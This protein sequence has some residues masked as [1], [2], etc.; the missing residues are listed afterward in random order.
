VTRVIPRG[1]SIEDL[2][3]FL[4]LLSWFA[5]ACGIDALGAKVEDDP[6]AASHADPPAGSQSSGGTYASG[7]PDEGILC[8]ANAQALV[9]CFA[10]E[11]NTTDDSPVRVT[12]LASAN[13]TY[14]V[15]REAQAA[16]FKPSPKTDV[17][18]PNTGMNTPQMTIEVWL[19]PA[20]LP[21]SGERFSIIDM[22][23]RFGITLQPDGT[24]RC[25]SLAT[26]KKVAVGT[27]THLA[28][29]ND[30]S[31]MSAFVDGLLDT[32]VANVLGTTSEFIGIGQ[33]STSTNDTYDGMMDNLRIWTRAL[34]T[35]EVAAAAAR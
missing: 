12:L 4:P 5:V 26:T 15:G 10:F 11:G 9:A 34:S 33:D 27:W 35:S 1:V 20:S 2:R 31:T 22:E 8:P 28:C 6:L 24:L 14:G 21:A 19:K 16:I 13:V 18:L 30:G 25:R 3:R 29:V 7:A 17:R 23:G 32:S